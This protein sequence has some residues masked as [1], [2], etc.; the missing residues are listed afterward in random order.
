LEAEG[1]KE[2]AVPLGAAVPVGDAFVDE[3]AEAEAET[4]ELVAVIDADDAAVE[5]DLDVVIGVVADADTAPD[6]EGASTTTRSMDF[7]RSATPWS[8]ETKVDDSDGFPMAD[9]T[10]WMPCTSVSTSILVSCRATMVSL[11][12]E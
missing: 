1:L 11:R 10:C 12:C 8:Q 9:S 6:C 5:E 4:A 3:A 7:M 2:E